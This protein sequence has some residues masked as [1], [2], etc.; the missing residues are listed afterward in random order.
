[1]DSALAAI[2]SGVQSKAALPE[3]GARTGAGALASAFCRTITVW[4]SS[5]WLRA[6]ISCS[7]K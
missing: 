4:T 7:V 3:V 2:F 1:M 5:S 6:E